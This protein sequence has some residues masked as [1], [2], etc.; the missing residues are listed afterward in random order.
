VST[1]LRSR[2]TADTGRRSP[3]SR[4]RPGCTSFRRAGRSGRGALSRACSLLR[5]GELTLLLLHQN[6]LAG[7]LA[8]GRLVVIRVDVDVLAHASTF[9]STGELSRE[10]ATGRYRR[11]ATMPPR[12][13]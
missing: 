10:L 2:C 7:P 5:A 13:A 8:P 4:R 1:R 12:S 11:L 9:L 3:A 6:V